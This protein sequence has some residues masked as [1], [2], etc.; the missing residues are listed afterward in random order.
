MER[1]DL[2]PAPP[3]G[4]A[5]PGIG[6]T[7]WSSPAERLAYADTVLAQH[8]PRSTG[9]ASALLWPLRDITTTC[10]HCGDTWPCNRV[11]WAQQTLLT[12]DAPR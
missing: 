5:V 8:R 10:T 1:D 11:A 4:E 12:Q 7:V 3:A 9:L 2:I 6:V